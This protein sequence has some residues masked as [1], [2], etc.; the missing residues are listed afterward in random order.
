MV[1]NYPFLI[2]LYSGAVLYIKYNKVK[3]NTLSRPAM[4]MNYKWY[5]LWPG[6]LIKTITRC[7]VYKS[8]RL[9]ASTQIGTNDRKNVKKNIIKCQTKNIT[10]IY[11]VKQGVKSRK[12]IRYYLSYNKPRGNLEQ[13]HSTPGHIQLGKQKI[14]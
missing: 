6:Q 8:P 2:S 14:H 12:Q 3:S 13:T 7:I 4:E 11:M 9:Q 5:K 10:G 1:I